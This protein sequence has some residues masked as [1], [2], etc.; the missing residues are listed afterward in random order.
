MLCNFT[1]LD[2]H[3][4]NFL[5]KY[6]SSH[7]IPS[8]FISQYCSPQV[9]RHN[10]IFASHPF[11]TNFILIKHLTCWISFITRDIGS[12]KEAEFFVVESWVQ[13]IL[14]NTMPPDGLETQGPRYQ[15]FCLCH[16][17]NISILAPAPWGLGFA[18]LICPCEEEKRTVTLRTVL[19]SYQYKCF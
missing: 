16:V 5:R 8:W 11:H 12:A 6:K 19:F 4:Y 18:L 2:G 10:Y 1:L 13:F 14:V 9:F 3:R 17:L 7:K 15:Q